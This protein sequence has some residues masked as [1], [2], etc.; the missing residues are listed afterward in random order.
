MKQSKSFYKTW[1]FWFINLILFI[2][3][4]AIILPIAII[5]NDSNNTT[6]ENAFE[7]NFNK[8]MIIP[9]NIDTIVNIKLQGTIKIGLFDINSN[10]IEF[11]TSEELFQNIDNIETIDLYY[12]LYDSYIKEYTIE[13]NYSIYQNRIM[14]KIFE[15]EFIWDKHNQFVNTYLEDLKIVNHGQV[16]H[17]D[18]FKNTHKN[19]LNNNTVQRITSIQ[20]YFNPFEFSDLKSGYFINNIF[21]TDEY[22]DFDY[23]KSY[24][25]S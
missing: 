18:C 5:D 22:V 12:C 19:D 8:E 9:N 25:M 2:V 15:K 20:N 1:W 10:L 21:Q 23:F 6:N 16:I 3:I 17:I 14:L 11:N 7:I 13:K 4:L 24:F